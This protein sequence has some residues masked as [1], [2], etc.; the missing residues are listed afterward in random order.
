M[1]SGTEGLIPIGNEPQTGT[2][3]EVEDIYNRI[4]TLS[5]AGKAQLIHKLITTLT[6]DEIA[7]ILDE[8]ST[9][10]RNSSRK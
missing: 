9:R 8:I 2:S 7:N 10:L 3:L 4:E 6:V 1:E 5:S